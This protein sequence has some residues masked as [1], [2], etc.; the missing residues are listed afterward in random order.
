MC[1]VTRPRSNMTNFYNVSYVG[2]TS[3]IL[4]ILAVFLWVLSASVYKLKFALKVHNSNTC[5]CI[6]HQ[7]NYISKNCLT[8]VPLHVIYA[9]Q[10]ISTCIEYV[11]FYAIQS[12]HSSDVIAQK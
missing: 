9:I 4:Y 5:A 6:D 3:L 10:H 7:S 11:L 2:N 12:M 1:S 8:S